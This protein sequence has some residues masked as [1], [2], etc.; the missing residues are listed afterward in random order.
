MARSLLILEI[1][2]VLNNNGGL[3]ERERERERER[4]REMKRDGE[5]DR[6]RDGERDGDKEHNHTPFNGLSVCSESIK[7]KERSEVVRINC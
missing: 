2:F 5:R 4:W 3:R 7:E 1:N 6:E